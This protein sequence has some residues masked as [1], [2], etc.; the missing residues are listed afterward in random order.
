MCVCFHQRY[1]LLCPVLFLLPQL[2]SQLG[3]HLYQ[4]RQV[5]VILQ[6]AKSPHPN[7]AFMHSRLGFLFL[8]YVFAFEHIMIYTSPF[9][10]SL[11]HNNRS[12]RK[13]RKKGKKRKVFPRIS[14][15]MK[16]FLLPQNTID[17]T[18]EIGYVHIYSLTCVI[19]TSSP[20]EKLFVFDGSWDLSGCSM[21]MS[22]K[23]GLVRSTKDRN[24]GGKF[25]R[26]ASRKSWRMVLGVDMI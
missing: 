19:Q 21:S 12:N 24:R 6:T 20:A 7:R 2:S 22:K 4:C 16:A 8:L 15:S 26:E 10:P 25:G 18:I 23:A 13:S 11:R 1:S 3:F 14:Q 9:L 17:V 5:K